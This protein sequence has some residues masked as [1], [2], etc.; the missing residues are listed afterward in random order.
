M[1]DDRSEEC[2]HE[3]FVETLESGQDLR[4]WTER[5]ARIGRPSVIRCAT[6]SATPLGLRWLGRLS[7]QGV[8]EVRVLCDVN[9]ARADLAP[10]I[11]DAFPQNTASVRLAPAEARSIGS[12]SWIVP[13]KS[14]SFSTMG[15]Q[16]LGP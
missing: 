8:A 2:V 9:Q 1:A 3:E 10:S 7:G 11:A 14:S 6:F 13:S 12:R 16:S 5:Q 4:R 15:Q